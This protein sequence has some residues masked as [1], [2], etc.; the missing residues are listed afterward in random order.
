MG[1][2]IWR[3]L[4]QNKSKQHRTS[5]D[6]QSKATQSNGKYI[7]ARPRQTKQAKKAPQIHV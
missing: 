6:Q 2:S 3:W 1:F 4:K 7:T 5:K